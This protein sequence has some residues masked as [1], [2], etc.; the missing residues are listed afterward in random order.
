MLQLLGPRSPADHAGHSR[1]RGDIVEVV[2]P[3]QTNGKPRQIFGE[4]EKIPVRALVQATGKDASTMLRL[5]IG[6]QVLK[7]RPLDIKAGQRQT[8]SFDLSAKELGP[9]THSAE[10][11]IVSKDSY[12][13]NDSRFI[14]FAIG[15]PKRVLILADDEG[16]ARGVKFALE[17]AGYQ[18]WYVLEQDV[19][20]KADPPAGGGPKADAVESVAYLAALAGSRA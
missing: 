11:K 16:Q 2:L 9:G 3:L 10:V 13:A 5:Q 12:A 8:V 19:S 18:G 14:T 6:S 15:K 4:D 1:L 20:L 7:D 17:D